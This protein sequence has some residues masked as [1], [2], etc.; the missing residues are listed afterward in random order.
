[1]KKTTIPF[2]LALLASAHLAQAADKG[3]GASFTAT[4]TTN[5]KGTMSALVIQQ[6]T[7]DGK[8]PSTTLKNNGTTQVE[9]INGQEYML[10]GVG[11]SDNKETRQL[12]N[13]PTFW[14][15]SR[16]YSF[17]AHKS[18]PNIK[19]DGI[20]NNSNNELLMTVTI[21]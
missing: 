7:S 20:V 18:T 16:K 21:S 3:K 13:M 8:L 9:L 2:I 19:L 5:V 14:N 15:H 1:M 4:I 12:H 6:T 10:S 17:R 11:N